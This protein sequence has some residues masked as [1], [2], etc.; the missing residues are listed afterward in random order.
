MPQAL[1]S[2]VS[3]PVSSILSGERLAGLPCPSATRFS[4]TR[5]PQTPQENAAMN[6][7]HVPFLWLAFNCK[8]GAV[9]C[10]GR[11]ADAILS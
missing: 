10:T 8:H 5:P 6:V 11:A 9:F 1:Q 2:F 3:K 4:D 7:D